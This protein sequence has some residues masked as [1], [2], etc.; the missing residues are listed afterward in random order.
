MSRNASVVIFTEGKVRSMGIGR[1]DGSLCVVI[2]SANSSYYVFQTVMRLN[3]YAA[4]NN[5]FLTII[6]A[7]S[8]SSVVE[9]LWSDRDCC[10]G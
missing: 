5:S 9:V 6:S 8:I 2:L 3:T 7:N 4:F 10:A 1:R